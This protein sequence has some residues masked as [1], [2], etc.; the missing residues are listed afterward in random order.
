VC[1]HQAREC[2]KVPTNGVPLR[3][4]SVILVAS[5]RGVRTRKRELEYRPARPHCLVATPLKSR[6][7]TQKAYTAVA[8][9]VGSSLSSFLR[10]NATSSAINPTNPHTILARL[11]NSTTAQQPVSTAFAIR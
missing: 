6:A 1:W 3:P 4:T 5:R 10:S 7:A 11:Y 9:A 2:R 8:G